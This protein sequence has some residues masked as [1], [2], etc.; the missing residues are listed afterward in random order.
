MCAP[1]CVCVCKC[2]CR[3]DPLFYVYPCGVQRQHLEYIFSFLHQVSDNSPKEFDHNVSD[4]TAFV[5][6]A[7]TDTVLHFDP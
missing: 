7:S 3:L 6:A 4:I 2:A 1:V 5:N